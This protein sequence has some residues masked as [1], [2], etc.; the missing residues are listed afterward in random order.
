M[1]AFEVTTGDKGR[2]LF[3]TGTDTGV[4]KTAVAAG[5]AGLLRRQG[6][7]VMAS[8]P[9]ATGAERVGGR[10]RSRDTLA[11]AAAAGV[12][13][14][15]DL[16][17]ITPL[18]FRAAAAPAVA[19]ALDGVELTLSALAELARGQARDRALLVVEGAGARLRRLP[20]RE[21]VADLAA[22]LGFPLVVVARRSLGTLNHTLM[23][24]EVARARGLA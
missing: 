13:D 15:L 16:D 22:A 24:V 5:V 14:G 19:A 7:A 9:V 18:L 8:K 12:A 17:R 6:R 4:G 3:F 20:R 11:L 1:A 21:T 2:G 23:T 10:W